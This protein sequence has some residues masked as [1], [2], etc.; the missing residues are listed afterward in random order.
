MQEEMAQTIEFCA[1][2][3]ISFFLVHNI[4]KNVQIFCMPPPKN[5]LLAP[6]F[7]TIFSDFLAPK[8]FYHLFRDF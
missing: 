7:A 4:G 2:N 1:K 5:T 8:N 6:L 3:F